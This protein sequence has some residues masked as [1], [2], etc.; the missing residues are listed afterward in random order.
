MTTLQATTGSTT[1]CPRCGSDAVAEI[2]Y[3]YPAFSED[4][5]KE[6]DSG[7]I[8]LGGC[9]VWDDQADLACTTCG[10]EFRSD[11]LEPSDPDDAGHA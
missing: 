11:G 8:V 9:V 4:L 6:M 3:G 1:T 5:R 10:L 7:H 2:L